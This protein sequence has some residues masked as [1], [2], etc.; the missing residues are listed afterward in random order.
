MAD[1]DQMSRKELLEARERVSLQIDRLSYGGYKSGNLT[2]TGVRDPKI[3]LMNELQAI[4]A[5]I[6]AEITERDSKKNA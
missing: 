5:E 4:L 3:E 2:N 1:P 6:N